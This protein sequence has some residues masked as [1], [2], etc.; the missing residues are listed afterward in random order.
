L[1]FFLRTGNKKGISKELNELPD[2]ELISL[3]K[4][5][6]DM[7]IIEI[8]FDRYT[9]IVF[10]ICMKYFKDTDIAKDAVMSIF[11]KLIQDFKTQ[12]IKTFKW[13]L[14]TVVRNYCLMEIRKNKNFVKANDIFPG[15]FHSE[16]MESGE[17]MH[18]LSFE[19]SDPVDVLL[20][21]VKSLNEHQKIC[22]E[23][24]YL[25][26][27]SYVDISLATGYSLKNVKSYIQN[28]K[29][30]LKI[31]LTTKYEKQS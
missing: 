20:E 19:N 18:L 31:Y 2:E 23:M 12:E 10:G 24:F 21:A 3:Y 17:D 6:D 26:E 8:I 9:H 11:E 27:K 22:I 1:A 7:K 5:G 15:K 16:V 28:G 4:A 30:N 14:N 29:R 25:D 13:W